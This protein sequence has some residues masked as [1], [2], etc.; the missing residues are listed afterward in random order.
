MGGNL[1]G[2]R[3]YCEIPTVLDDPEHKDAIILGGVHT[4]PHNREFSSKDMS[5]G[6]HWHPT[7]FYNAR[8]QRILERQLMMFF[9]ERTGECRAYLY[10][11]ATRIVSALREGKWLP[12]GKASDEEGNIQLFEGQDWLP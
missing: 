8:T 7:R 6:A 5:T 3:K 4:H 10:N 1:S 9:R 11:N 12:I 2:G